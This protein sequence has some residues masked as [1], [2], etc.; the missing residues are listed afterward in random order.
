MDGWYA[1]NTGAI[2]CLMYNDED[3]G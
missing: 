1:E 3:N 2:F